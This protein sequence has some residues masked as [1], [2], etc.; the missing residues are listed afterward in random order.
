LIQD[1]I[2]R[3]GMS[4]ISLSV[5]PEVSVYMRLPRAIYVRFPT[6]NPFGEAFHPAQHDLVLEAALLALE[7]ID[8]PGTVLELP[9]RWRRLGV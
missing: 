3:A 7:R 5:R 2:E 6:G 8:R 4:T 1:A 9:F